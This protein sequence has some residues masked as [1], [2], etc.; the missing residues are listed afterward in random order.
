MIKFHCFMSE[1]MCSYFECK[2]VYA[3]IIG[4]REA[5]L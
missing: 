4:T 3:R 5:K 2:L 1:N